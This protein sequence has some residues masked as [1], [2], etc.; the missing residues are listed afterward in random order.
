MVPVRMYDTSALFKSMTGGMALKG[1]F[2]SAP[3]DP[4]PV[5]EGDLPVRLQIKSMKSS[6][7]S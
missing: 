7:N 3:S 6:G 4:N 5:V 2:V 1:P